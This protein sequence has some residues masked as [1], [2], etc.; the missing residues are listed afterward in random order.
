MSNQKA[1]LSTRRTAQI[2]GLLFMLA[3]AT[4]FV[5]QAFYG[6]ILG[7]SDYL[8]IVYPSRLT[9]MTGV[10]V[11]FAG[12]LGL[13]FIPILLYPFLKV[14]N[15]VIAWGYV[16][17]RL[18][19]VVLLTFAQI[20]KLSI[21]GLSKNYLESNGDASVFQSMGNMIHSILMWVDSGGLLYIM[22]FVFGAV[23]FYIALF[24]T[25][26]VPTW[27]SVFGLVSALLLL[28]GSVLFYYDCVAAETAVLF[29]LPLA[30]QEQVMAV[31][32]IFKGFNLSMLI[33]DSASSVPDAE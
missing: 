7:S 27:I 19:E 1:S 3:T 26:L 21:I 13:M 18:M 16:G 22:V 23:I 9:V 17:I 25:R 20:F 2:V 8:E 28:S 33:S 11:E 12:F 15:Q 4:L 29:M 32:M 5:G 6:Q 30:L 31:W 10:L 24:K 14:Y